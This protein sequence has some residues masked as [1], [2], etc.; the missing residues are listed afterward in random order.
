METSTLTCLASQWAGLYML[1]FLM[2]EGVFERT[3]RSCFA[4]AFRCHCHLQCRICFG[5]GDGQDTEGFSNIGVSLACCNYFYTKVRSQMTS[6]G[7]LWHVRISKLI[8]ETNLQIYELV[9][10]RYS[11]YRKVIPKL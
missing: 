10:A 6:V 4:E 5:L 1:R 9:P 11:F 7:D 2:L 8:S 3:V